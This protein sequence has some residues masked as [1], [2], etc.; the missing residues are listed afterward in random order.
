[1]PGVKPDP[2]GE[3]NVSVVAAALDR[4]DEPDKARPAVRRAVPVA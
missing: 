1:M 4:G 2:E 3:A